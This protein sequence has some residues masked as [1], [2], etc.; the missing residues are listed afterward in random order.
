MPG[1]FS[2]EHQR[3]RP[4]L[5]CA[6]VA[7]ALIAANVATARAAPP[8]NYLE[9]HGTRAYPI[10]ALLWGMMLVC[11]A[12]VIVTGTLLAIAVFRKRA[13]ALAS[14]PGLSPIGREEDG[15]PWIT[16]GVGVS[17]AILF[18]MVVWTA[19]VLAA[20]G[21]QP[22]AAPL[23]LEV[24]AHQWWWE[25]R[26]LDD[27]PSRS[28][29]TANEIHIPTGQRIAV[30]LSA[31]DVIHSFWVP[32]L[33][34]KTDTIPGQT[35]TTWIEAD[36]P[37]VFQGQCTE[38]CGHQHAHMGFQVIASAPD[39]FDAWKAAQLASPPPAIE[40]AAHD[41]DVFVAKCGICHVVRGTRAGGALGPDLSHLMGRRTLAAAMLPNTPDNLARWIT[42]PQGVKPGTLM[43]RPSLA[44]DDLGRITRYL[45]SLQ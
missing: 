27:D 14:L 39:D 10:T 6:G 12:V 22:V 31:P 3:T 28:F 17:T 44:G 30:R 23:S 9:A 35:N 21:Q 29:R 1:R 41:Q 24:V 15:L 4:L 16:I 26:Y 2:P 36:R 18:G 7:A 42:D 5:R 37:G 25:V 33:S 32:A 34:G 43:P 20:V 13:G 38:Y 45:S 11:V 40:E 8:L 19:V